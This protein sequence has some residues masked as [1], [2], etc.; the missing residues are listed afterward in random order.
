MQTQSPFPFVSFRLPQC[1]QEMVVEDGISSKQGES[2]I[3][4]NHEFNMEGE[5]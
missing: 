1:M 5:G 3:T 2:T 4:T